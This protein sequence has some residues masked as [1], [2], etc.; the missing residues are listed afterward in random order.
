MEIVPFKFR[1]VFVE[2][3]GLQ[4]GIDLLVRQKGG[5]MFSFQLCLNEE[6]FLQILTLL[7]VVIDPIIGELRCQLS[8]HQSGKKLFSHNGVAVEGC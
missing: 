4:V 6:F 3:C 2:F 5:Q 7:L 8:W 1:K